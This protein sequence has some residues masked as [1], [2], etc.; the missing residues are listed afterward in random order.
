MICK[1]LVFSKMY[2]GDNKLLN[3]IS[4]NNCCLKIQENLD[5]ACQWS[6]T[7]LLDSNISNCSL[8]QRMIH[9]NTA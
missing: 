5:N 6:N 7:W 4:D 1:M 9:L 2:A 8:D 3:S